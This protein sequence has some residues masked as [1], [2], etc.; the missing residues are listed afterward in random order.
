M[1]RLCAVLSE[2]VE[3]HSFQTH[4]VSKISL[5]ITGYPLFVKIILLIGKEY[6]N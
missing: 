6:P 1:D 3:A 4:N 5:K 2:G